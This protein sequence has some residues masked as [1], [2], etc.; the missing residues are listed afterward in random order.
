MKSRW[1]AIATTTHD[2]REVEDYQYATAIRRAAAGMVGKT[3]I[4]VQKKQDDLSWSLVTIC[5]DDTPM[6][7]GSLAIMET[8][9][10]TREEFQSA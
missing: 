10:S 7:C 9:K 6:A 8:Y 3:R 1:K 4:E 5:H 2:H